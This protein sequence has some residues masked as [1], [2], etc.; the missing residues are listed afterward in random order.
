MRGK[1]VVVDRVVK[2]RASFWTQVLI[3]NT[4]VYPLRWCSMK[5]YAFLALCAVAILGGIP[6][7]AQDRRLGIIGEDD[8]VPVTA[9]GPPWDAIGQVN[10]GGLRF[11]GQC[12]GTLVAADIVL[13]AAHC[14]M[15]PWRKTPF[16]LHDIHFLVAVRGPMN[17]G[18]STAKCL[19][20]PKDYEF[21]PPEKILP[22]MPA[23]KVPLRELGKDVVTIVL[24]DKLVVDPAPLADGVAGQPGLLL[25]HAAYPVDRRFALT[26]HFNCHLLRSDPELRPLWFND[27]DTH[28]ASSGGPLFT[29]MEGTLELAAIMLGTGERSFNVALPI[30]EWEDLAKDSACP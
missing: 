26:A 1:P 9:Q 14:V 24:N 6:V 13:T 21:V 3:G 22:T 25:V 30:S 10:I 19:H 16:P 27:C 20:F 12:T 15:D 8:R 17:K 5:R 28:P 2:S 11:T 18:H 29:N 7:S 4:E 23:Q